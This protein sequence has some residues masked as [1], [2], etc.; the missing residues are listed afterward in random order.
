M[1][2]AKNIK[3]KS[4]AN[5]SITYYISASISLQIYLFTVLKSYIY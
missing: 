1:Y 2:G 3:F 5:L 4:H